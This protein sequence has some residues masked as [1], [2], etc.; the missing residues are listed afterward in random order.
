[1]SKEKILLVDDE[2]DIIEFLGYNLTKEGY[3]VTTSTSGKE[4]VEIAKRINPDLILLDVMMPEKDG[5][6]VLIE[7]KNDAQLKDVPVIMLSV[8]D[9]LE[10]GYVLGAKGYL[11]KP[12]R[13]ELLLET[14]ENCI[15]INNKDKGPVLILDDD[16]DAQ[17]LRDKILS[18][19]GGTPK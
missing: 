17:L 11:T 1:M 7:L 14:I 10:L 13:K 3:D 2:P 16:E 9:S 8:L 15:P 5:W 18:K 19:K 12:I 6:N 4:A